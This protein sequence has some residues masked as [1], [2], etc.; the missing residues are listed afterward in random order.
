LRNVEYTDLY[1]LP[2]TLRFTFVVL[3]KWTDAISLP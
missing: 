2:G 1:A 3:L